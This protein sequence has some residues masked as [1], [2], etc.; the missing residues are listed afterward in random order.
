MQPIESAP[1]P[2]RSAAS[3]LAPAAAT[4]SASAMP[5]AVASPMRSKTHPGEVPTQLPTMESLARYFL[6]L[7]SPDSAS[8]SGT[9]LDCGTGSPRI[10]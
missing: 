10:P 9:L 4:P 3:V 8:L 2:A 5:R 1:A 7:A 6:Y